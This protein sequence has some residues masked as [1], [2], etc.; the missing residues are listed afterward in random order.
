MKKKKLINVLTDAMSRR[1]KILVEN[2]PLFSSL[3]SVRD[4]TLV[5]NMLNIKNNAVP[6]GTILICLF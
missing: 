6:N 3:C 4:I 5:K 1:D 2:N